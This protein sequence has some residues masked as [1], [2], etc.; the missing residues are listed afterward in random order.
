[1][2]ISYERKDAGMGIGDG[3]FTLENTPSGTLVW[4]FMAGENV[5]I[6][7]G[8]EVMSRILIF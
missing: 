5:N 8:D 4:K 7:N 1:M 3:L 2:Q 6:Y